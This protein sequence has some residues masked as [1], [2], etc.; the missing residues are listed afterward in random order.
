MN[1]DTAR[2][3]DHGEQHWQLYMSFGQCQADTQS[4]MATAVY[5]PQLFDIS[6]VVF[7]YFMSLCFVICAQ[8]ILQHVHDNSISCCYVTYLFQDFAQS[9]SDL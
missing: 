7:V 4:H 8:Q 3:S 2:C 1:V 6:N 9:V 5:N